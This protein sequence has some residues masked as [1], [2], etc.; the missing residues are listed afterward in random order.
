MSEGVFA[1]LQRDGTWW[2]NNAGAITGANGTII[3]DTCATDDRTRRFLDAVACGAPQGP[4][5]FAVN[6]YHHGDHTYGNS[7]LPASTVIV[8]HEAMRE[9]LAVDFVIDGCPA[10]WE[11]VPIWGAITVRLPD[12]TISADTVIHSGSRRVE[13]RHPGEPAH[14]RGDLVA[15]L[16]EERILFAGDLV[17]AGLTPLAFM[18]SIS[19]ALRA[20]DWIAAFEPLQLVPGHGP[21][22]ETAGLSEVLG[23]HDRYY[24][25]VLDTARTGVGLGLSPL[26]MARRVDLGEFADWPDPERL[27]LNLHRAYHD[28]GYLSFNLIQAFLDAMEWNGGPFATHVCCGPGATVSCPSTRS[29]GGPGP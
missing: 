11:P 10:F 8:G 7:L 16:P 23:Q 29:A 26:E 27:V 22:V 17:F 12:V 6:T 18:G 20:L 28:L 9:E 25:F 24:R 2:V 19:G 21:L 4:T 13:L 14:T 1:W 5:R 15:W 3:V